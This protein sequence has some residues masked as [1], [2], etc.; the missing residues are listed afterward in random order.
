MTYRDILLAGL[1]YP[2]ATPD[3]ALRSGVALARK[4]GG[5][6]TLAAIR[7]RFPILH[8]RLANALIDLDKMA[9]DASRQSEAKARQEGLVAEIA[10]AEAGG[11]VSILDLAAEF[12][13]EAD[14]VTVVARTRDLT[15]VPIGP[16][17]LPDEALAETVLFGSGRPVMIYPEAVEIMP[18]DSFHDVAIAWDG[19]APA[20]RAVADALPLLERAARISIFVAVQEKPQAK[21][22]LAED[23]AR[24]LACHGVTATVHEA[25]AKGQRIGELLGAYVAANAVELLVMGGFGHSRTREFLLGGATASILAAPPCPVLLSH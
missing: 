16:T 25:P 15:L 3:R 10:A 17:V 9:E 13:T 12:G 14:A 6:L 22:G 5:Q 21:A 4:V 7:S 20:A 19:G 8:N 18:A 1:T 24:H 11:S 2:D 23:L